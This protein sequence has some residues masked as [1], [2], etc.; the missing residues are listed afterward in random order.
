[1]KLVQ[2]SLQ[3]NV[4][5]HVVLFCTSDKVGYLGAERS[6]KHSAKEVV[7]YVILSF[8]CNAIKKIL[9]KMSCHRHFK[10]QTKHSRGCHICISG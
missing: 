2:N 8:F 10:K 3:C 1:M 4:K 9:D 6:Y 7:S 5:S